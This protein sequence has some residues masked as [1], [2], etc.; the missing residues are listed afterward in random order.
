M[1][2]IEADCITM[3]IAWI[4]AWE[5]AHQEDSGLAL[6][7]ETALSHVDGDMQLLSELA[8]MFLQD[9]PRLAEEA[10]SAIA[11]NDGVVLERAAHTLKG[12]LAFFGITKIHKQVTRLEV[13]GRTGDFSGAP[14]LLLEINAEME[15]ILPEFESLIQEQHWW[16][17]C[18]RRW[19]GCW[20]IV[21][22]RLGAFMSEGSSQKEPLAAPVF[23]LS[24]F[25]CL[26]AA[27]ALLPLILS[28]AIASLA[29][30]LKTA[31]IIIGIAMLAGAVY[32]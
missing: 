6:N 1:F 12:R 9:Y 17:F 3:L 10:L 5:M 28:C 22:S 2:T 23:T 18:L 24:R 20:A 7:L 4:E 21:E 26:L 31:L 14:Q 30:G 8:L 27:G 13:I 16:K 11:Q 15:S 25:C 29:A 19:I 32:W